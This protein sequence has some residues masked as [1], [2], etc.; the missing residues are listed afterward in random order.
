MKTLVLIASIA[1]LAI[2]P[3]TLPAMPFIDVEA[4]IGAWRQSPSGYVSYESDDRLDLEELFEYDAETRLLGRLKVD[5]P[6][7]I[8]NI[9]LVAAPV[10]FEETAI[11]DDFYEF[12]GIVIVPGVRFQSELDLNQYDVGLYY[13]IPLLETATFKLLNVE[14]GVN[15]KIYDAKA[16]VS[17]QTVPGIEVSESEEETVVIPM[18]YLGLCVRPTDRFAFEGEFRGITYRDSDFYS[19][20]GRL[21]LYTF[22]PHFIAGGYR[23]D[24]GTSDEWD[25]EFDVDF[26]GA[27][28]ETGFAF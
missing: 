16:S 9:Y 14:A 13:D 7:L 4:S 17:Q 21:K 22:G 12:G 23:H 8:P 19:L 6:L 26:A 11:T 28:V 5:M 27:F 2:M 1:V 24:T 15:F 10:K 18:A 25:L 20:I 3:A